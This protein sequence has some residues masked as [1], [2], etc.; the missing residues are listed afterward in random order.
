MNANDL[1]TAH[2]PEHRPAPSTSGLHDLFVDSCRLGPAPTR[3]REGAVIIATVVLIALVVVLLQPP[4]LLA[5]IVTGVVAVHLAVR[6]VLGTR[7]WGRS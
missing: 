5:A 4:L 6:W 2:R 7:K 3:A 1:H